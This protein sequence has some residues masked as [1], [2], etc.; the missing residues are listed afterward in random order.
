MTSI[1]GK[2]ADRMETAMRNVHYKWQNVLVSSENYHTVLSDVDKQKLVYL[3]ADS[4]NVIDSLSSDDI[5]IIGGLV[6]KNRHKVDYSFK[7]LF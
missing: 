2:L 3:T 5:Y 1:T 6:D 7:C 4:E